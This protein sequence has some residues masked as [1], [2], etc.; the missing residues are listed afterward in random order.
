MAPEQK[1]IFREKGCLFLS[2]ALPRSEVQPIKHHVLDELRRRRIWSSGKTLAPSIK[3]I[4][5]FQQIGKVS[6]QIR[7]DN[8][9]A[10][11]VN[12]RIVL[13]IASLAEAKL[14]PAHSQFLVSLPNQGNWTLQGLNWHTDISPSGHRRVPGIQA[15]V[16]LDDVM[17][18]GGATLAIAGSHL[19][20]EREGAGRKVRAI[21]RERGDLEG[22]LRKLDLSII[23]MSGRAGDVYLMDMRVLHTPSI[24]SARQLRI[25]ATVRYLP[26]A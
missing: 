18:H 22:E 3:R 21:L 4:P 23:E 24:N 8:L 13:A 10:R 25:M 26:A 14:V 20:A 15:F 5:A 1:A 17:P 7:L 19:L 9:H 6:E 12:A 2:A 11:I 16:L